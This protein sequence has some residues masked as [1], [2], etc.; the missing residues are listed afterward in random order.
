MSPDAV[1]AELVYRQLKEE[2]LAGNY[3]P[4]AVL[5]VHMIATGIGV[6]ISPVRDAM[7]RLV[8]E[9]ILAVRP[10]GGFQMPQMSEDAAR[11]LYAWHGWLVRGAVRDRRR[12]TCGDELVRTVE[13]MDAA[14][15]EALVS[16]SADLFYRIAEMADSVEHLLAVRF[17][18]ER[19]HP[20]RV[21]EKCLK[22]RKAELR[23]LVSAAVA[24][25]AAPL[26]NALILY[27][28]RR[29]RNISVLVSA[30]YI[31]ANH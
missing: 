18:N 27:H 23:R 3:P 6:S 28:R 22:D 9:R 2:V 19:L 7:A 15:S 11:D 12:I 14:D 1:A 4:T 20:L 16:A 10:G 21:A 24:G 29:H 26:R 30:L 31:Q 25:Q 5:N 8:G 17:A 13:R